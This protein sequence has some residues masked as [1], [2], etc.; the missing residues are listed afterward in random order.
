MADFG[1]LAGAEAAFARAGGEAEVWEAGGHYVEG[2]N[3]SASLNS[4]TRI[5]SDVDSNSAR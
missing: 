4:S 3:V 2:W 5:V 1:L